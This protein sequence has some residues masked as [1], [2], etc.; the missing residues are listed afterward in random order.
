LDSPGIQ[1]KPLKTQR[2][3]AFL[4]FFGSAF[5]SYLLILYWIPGVMVRYGE[6]SRPLSMVALIALAAFLSIFHGIAGIVI[7]G[8][9][10]P[11]Y[12]SMGI[13]LI[14]LIWVCKDLVIEKIFGGFPWCLAGYSQ[15]KNIYFV[16][17]AEIGGIHLVTF[18]LVYF[19]VLVYRF[20]RTRDKRTAAAILVSLFAVYTVGF[21]LYQA[22][23]HDNRG[24]DIHRAGIIQ[25][26]TNN[27]PITRQEKDK[28]LNRLFR[29]SGELA[30]K[31]AE[32]IVW[33]EHSVAIYPL[34]NRD[35]YDRFESFV[36]INVPLLAGFTDLKGFNEIYNSAVLFGKE[37]MQ[38]YDKVHLTPFGEYVL[39]RDILFF[40]RRITDEIADFTPGEQVRSLEIHNHYISTP[41]CYEII[42]PELVRE[43]IAKGGELIITISNDSWFGDTSAPYQHLSMAVFRSIENR[44]YI[45][46]STSNGISAVI[47]P[48]GEIRYRSAYHT[49]DA[50]IARFKYIKKKTFFNC[51][52]YLFPYFCVFLLAVYFVLYFLAAKAVGDRSRKAKGRE[53]EKKLRS[54]AKLMG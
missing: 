32:F 26:D 11:A 6:M 13:L 47:A 29:E 5:L 45:L 44:R 2:S 27:V 25:P 16:Q 18:L 19:N 1:Q 33:P 20:I 37:K 14:P 38:K 28:I 53:E 15:Y 51:C 50:F 24:L 35:D 12:K 46:R 17:V 7:K 3:R 4:L 52:G 43:F 9:A 40:V 22:D 48:S 42:F 23:G 30:K 21:Y 10:P 34:Q 54:K 31:G 39:F 49:A 41:I 36:R 8:A